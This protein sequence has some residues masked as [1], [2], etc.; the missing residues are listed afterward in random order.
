MVPLSVDGAV[1]KDIADTV[2]P[3][4]STRRGEESGMASARENGSRWIK[5]KSCWFRIK[6]VQGV[7]FLRI[8]WVTIAGGRQERYIMFLS[9][10]VD[11]PSQG[12][13]RELSSDRHSST[14]S[15]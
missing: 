14:T 7:G 8:H 4:I 12:A 6:G 13:W 1:F 9:L 10:S 11:L 3:S 2:V 15:S 5:F